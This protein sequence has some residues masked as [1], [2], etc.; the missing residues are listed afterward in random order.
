MK[1]VKTALSKLKRCQDLITPLKL[2]NLRALGVSPTIATEWEAGVK[3]LLDAYDAACELAASKS[4]LVKAYDAAFSKLQRAAKERLLSDPEKII[5]HAA[6]AAQETAYKVARIEI[7]APPPLAH[8]R[9]TVEA[10]W[11]S[12]NIRFKL[13]QAGCSFVAQLKLLARSPTAPKDVHTSINRFG[14]YLNA[15][16]DRAQEDARTAARTAVKNNAYRQELLSFAYNIKASL[17]KDRHAVDK[18]LEL[19]RSGK[20]FRRE[21]MRRETEERLGDL[22]D[23]LDEAI[24]RARD[25]VA[26]SREAMRQLDGWLEETLQPEVGRSKEQYEALLRYISEATFYQEVSEEEKMAVIGAL[27]VELSTFTPAGHW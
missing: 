23:E 8:S 9:V 11:T 17:M 18:Q 1:E 24:E 6:L 12:I 5:A 10:I 3:S 19:A 4:P 16:L 22:M 20:P 14:V 7:G 13:Y 27:S 15:I 21:D 26:G 25:N 2:L